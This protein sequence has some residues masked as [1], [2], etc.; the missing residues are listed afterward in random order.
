MNET[1]M[2]LNVNTSFEI[3]SIAHTDYSHCVLL[4]TLSAY[5]YIRITGENDNELGAG[6]R[7]CQ[8]LAAIDRIGTFV[9]LV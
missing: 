5:I 4:I 3:W 2:Q 6:L 9:L 8:A 7:P 1:D